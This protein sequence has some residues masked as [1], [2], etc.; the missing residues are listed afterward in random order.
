MMTKRRKIDIFERNNCLPDTISSLTSFK[1][2]DALECLDSH[3][4][5]KTEN[6]L[7]IIR[8]QSNSFVLLKSDQ[9]KKVVCSQ[10][11]LCIIITII[12]SQNLFV[13]N[14]DPIE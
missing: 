7:F 4:I 10:L 5:I 8:E 1:S 3:Q 12:I 9:T 11:F 6:I 14:I 13:I 2:S